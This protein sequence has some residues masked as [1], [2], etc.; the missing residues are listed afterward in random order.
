MR[1]GLLPQS[2][3]CFEDT[4]FPPKVLRSKD[5]FE[6]G[7][8]GVGWEGEES[9]DQE[10]EES[11]WRSSSGRLA[12]KGG[13]WPRSQPSGPGPCVPRAPGLPRDAPR[14][15][16]NED[17]SQGSEGVPWQPELGLGTRRGNSCV[18]RL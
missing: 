1:K 2:P 17:A 11:G 15:V 10:Q 16:R 4:R 18:V 6:V 13:P 3:L 7:L 12:H 9:E 8:W 5:C 14:R